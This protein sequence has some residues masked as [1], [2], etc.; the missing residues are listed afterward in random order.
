MKGRARSAPFL[1]GVVALSSLSIHTAPTLLTRRRNKKGHSS[2]KAAPTSARVSGSSKAQAPPQSPSLLDSYLGEGRVN[3]REY[4]EQDAK[5]ALVAEGI[6]GGGYRCHQRVIF[7][8]RL[9]ERQEL[10]RRL[11]HLQVPR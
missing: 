9:T 8:V 10:G 4:S 7:G 3:Y 5:E 6:F 11:R 2:P 1:R